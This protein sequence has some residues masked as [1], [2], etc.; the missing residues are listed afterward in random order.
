MY[1]NG[2]LVIEDVHLEDND[3]VRGLRHPST[4]LYDVDKMLVAIFMGPESRND[5]V[6]YGIAAKDAGLV[7]SF[8]IREGSDEMEQF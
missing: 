3:P 7:S 8:F 5:A 6:G 4:E 2:T 1:H